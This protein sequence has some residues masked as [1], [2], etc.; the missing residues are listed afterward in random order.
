MQTAVCQK[1]WSKTVQNRPSMTS[2]YDFATAFYDYCGVLGDVRQELM[3]AFERLG[4]TDDMPAADVNHR[5]RTDA[6]AM[7][8]VHR[9]IAQFTV[10]CRWLIS[11]Y[12]LYSYSRFAVHP[13]VR[14]LKKIEGEWYGEK[15]VA[16][17]YVLR[18]AVA[19]YEECR[20]P[21]YDV[22]PGL[23]RELLA[24]TVKNMPEEFL[25]PPYPAMYLVCPRSPAFRLWHEAD[26][27]HDVEGVYVV[28]DSEI[29]PRSLRFLIVGLPNEKAVD[30]DDDAYYY[31]SMYLRP[32]T[33]LD[34]CLKFSLDVGVGRQ[35]L[36]RRLPGVDTEIISGVNVPESISMLLKKNLECVNGVFRYALNAMLYATH[37]DAEIRQ[38]NTSAEYRALR[39]RALKVKGKKRRAL[40]ARALSEKG[41]DRK[42]LGE[43]VVVSRGLPADCRQEPGSGKEGSPLTVRTYVQ[44][45]WQVYW[46]GPRNGP[47]ERRYRHK[48]AYWRG[49]KD[50]AIGT[51]THFMKS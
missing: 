4:L 5:L 40:L 14:A 6:L 49:P 48:R 21:V 28:E 44:S 41:K 2:A 17:E 3:A 32:G 46:V 16:S 8:L 37:P 35:K 13:A 23:S 18:H 12:K 10:V 36:T 26:G 29:E 45:H 50:G 25:T 22:A 24:T 47:R 31:W 19:L 7:K 15:H 1:A 38:F 20:E 51:T 27:L 42:L 9:R 30:G 11:T 34:E 39:R 33:T 43:S